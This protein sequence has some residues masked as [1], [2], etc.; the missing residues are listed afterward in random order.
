MDQSGSIFTGFPSTLLDH[1]GGI[2]GAVGAACQQLHPD[3]VE[4][5]FSKC[6]T[7]EKKLLGF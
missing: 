6:K 1:C 4:K 3:T 7:K 5:A 2:K